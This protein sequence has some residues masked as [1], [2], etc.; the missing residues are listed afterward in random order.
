MCVCVH[1]CLCVCRCL[2]FLCDDSKHADAVLPLCLALTTFNLSRGSWEMVCLYYVC[3]CG[4][5]VSYGS[6]RSNHS[7]TPGGPPEKPVAKHWGILGLFEEEQEAL[8]KA[9]RTIGLYTAPAPQSTLFRGLGG[10]LGRKRGRN[11]VLQFL[12][13]HGG[14]KKKKKNEKGIENTLRPFICFENYFFCS[15]VLFPQK[16]SCDCAF[17]PD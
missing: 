5:L 1:V 12:L 11:R 14:K 2:G 15:H 6:E 7:R 16:S 10:G 8:S 4:V 9:W 3:V 17:F 13:P